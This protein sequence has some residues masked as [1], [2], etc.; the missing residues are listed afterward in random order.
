[1]TEREDISRALVTSESVRSIATR[2]QRAP[3]TVS[4]EIQRNDGSALGFGERTP[5]LVSKRGAS[6]RIHLPQQKVLGTDR[7]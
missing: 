5:P 7:F 2:L 6:F 1:M 3:Y 4:R